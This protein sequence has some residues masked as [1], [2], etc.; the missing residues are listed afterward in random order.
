[1]TT[2]SEQR[3]LCDRFGVVPDYPQAGSRLGI[4]EGAL[5][6]SEPLHGLRQ[7][8]DGLSTWYIWSG[9]YSDSNDFFRS[10]HYEHVAEHRP[11]ALAY[12]ALPAGWRFLLAEGFEDVWFDE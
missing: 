6:G 3:A 7:R 11:E 2:I 10:I 1:M 12:L 9:E 4:S 8:A 5:R